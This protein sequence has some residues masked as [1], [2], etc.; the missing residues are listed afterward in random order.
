VGS[1]PPL[2]GAEKNDEIHVIIIEGEGKGFCGGYDL[3]KYAGQK[4]DGHSCGQEKEPWDPMVD[5]ATMKR[6]T[7]DVMSLWR[8]QPSQK[9]TA[10]RWPVVA[11]S[12]F[13]GI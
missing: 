6:F 3:T 12:H 9:S 5:Y 2:S 4:N 10:L 7:E 8:G 1:V 11:T 13:A